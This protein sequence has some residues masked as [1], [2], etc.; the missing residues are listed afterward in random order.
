M[1]PDP[2]AV[3]DWNRY[4]FVRFN[5]L[6][7]VDPSGHM[8]CSPHRDNCGDEDDNSPWIDDQNSGNESQPTINN[9]PITYDETGLCVQ[10]AGCSNYS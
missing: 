6:R 10:G 3:L 8:L 7:Y 9:S 5:P 2:G 1:V 4:A